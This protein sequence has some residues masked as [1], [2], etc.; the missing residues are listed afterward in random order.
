MALAALTVSGL[1]A[2][3][4]LDQKTFQDDAKVA[5]KITSIRLANE[6]GDVKVSASADAATI[7]VHRKVDYRGDRPTGTSF[8]VENGV[9]MLSDCGD[10]CDVSYVVKVPAGLPVT[11][12][13]SNGNLSLTDA[14]TVDVRT[15]NGEIAVTRA[16]GPVKLRTSNGD[17][18]V[19]DVKDG[20]IDTHT[21]NGEVT[22][23]TAVPQNIKARTTSGNLTVKAPPA[24]YRISAE[25]AHGDQSVAFKNDPSGKYLLDL[26]TTNGDLTVKS[27]G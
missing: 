8:R 21:S 16:A 11:G 10:D 15:S 5:R 25:D 20:G 2:C 26:A 7:S 22:I 24:R 17:V 23:Q 4:A 1:S 18:H 27:A 19:T 12:G 13:T 6:N 14:G 3:S 9:L